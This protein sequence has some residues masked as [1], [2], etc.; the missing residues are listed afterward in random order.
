MDRDPVCGMEMRPGQE[1]A[2]V[3][4]QNQT[5]HFCSSECKQ[6]FEARPKDYVKEAMQ[7]ETS[8]HQ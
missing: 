3:T 7:A 4:Y 1:A 6:M 2:S 5:F 8:S